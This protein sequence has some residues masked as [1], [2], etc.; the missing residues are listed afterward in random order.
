MTHI[1]GGENVDLML[2]L[3]HKSLEGVRTAIIQG[4]IH[5][6]LVDGS[7]QGTQLCEDLLQRLVELPRC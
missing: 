6:G 3:P 5:I 2:L 4:V 1:L 7:R